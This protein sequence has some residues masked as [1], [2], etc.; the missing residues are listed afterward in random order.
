MKRSTRLLFLILIILSGAGSSVAQDHRY[1]VHPWSFGV[2][3]DTQ[4][5]PGTQSKPVDPAGN[6]PNFVSVSIN[7]QLNQQF[8]NHRV[9]FVIGLGD[10]SNWAGDA[11]MA[12]CAEAAADL[13]LHNIAFFPMRGNHETYGATPGYSIS[14]FQKNFPQT[15]GIGDHLFGAANF[16]SPI[17]VSADLDGMSENSG[18]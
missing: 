15:R 17:A 10:N 9:K 8:I 5:R 7:R 12:T 3:G 6:N 2:M 1:H 16:S 18:Y 14:S 11:A 4:W 13:Y